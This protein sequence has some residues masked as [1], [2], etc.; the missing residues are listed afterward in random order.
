MPNQTGAAGGNRAMAMQVCGT[1][2][3]SLTAATVIAG[4]TLFDASSRTQAGKDDQVP[5]RMLASG[6]HEIADW[7]AVPGQGDSL[8]QQ[9]DE[10]S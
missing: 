9:R 8:A 5:A 7:C 3:K 4:R 1:D 6:C 10:L 2:R